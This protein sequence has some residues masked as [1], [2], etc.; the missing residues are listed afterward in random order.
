MEKISDIKVTDTES[1]LVSKQKPHTSNEVKKRYM[2]K[3]YKR[4]T[5]NLRKIEDYDVIKFLNAEKQRGIN[6]TDVLR[7]FIRGEYM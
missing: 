3:T 7:K 5:A 4:Y 1:T 2:D 6:P